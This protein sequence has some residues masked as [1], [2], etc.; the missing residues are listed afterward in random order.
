VRSIALT[1]LLALSLAFAACGSDEGNES[2]TPVA[3]TT[4]PRDYVEA[5]SG[6]PEEVLLDGETPISDCI[7]PDQSPADLS[8]IGG[9][10]VEASSE[11]NAEAREDPAGEASLQLGYLVGSVEEGASTTQGAHADLVRRLSASARYA[12]PQGGTLPAAFERQFGAGYAAAR[13]AG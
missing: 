11:L 2:Q 5:L 12:G 1:T 8:D 13:E 3:C 10:L 6:A 4:D 7:V 9:A